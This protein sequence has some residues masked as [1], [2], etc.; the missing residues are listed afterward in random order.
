ML[1]VELKSLEQEDLVLERTEWAQA[2]GIELTPE[3]NREPLVIYCELAKNG[4]MISAKGWVKSRML[5][6]C[7]RC[8][9][10]FEAPFKSFFEVHYRPQ[11]D[12][13]VETEEG[14]PE[15]EMEVVYF[16][17]D[18]LDIGDQIRQTVLLSVPMRALCKDDCRGLCGSCG[19][20][21]NSE[22]CDCQEPPADP[23]WDALKSFKF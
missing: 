6:T 12:E 13:M 11:P 21:L 18:I 7:G 22:S 4:D 15:G 2:L 3:V 14:F 23:R 20:D 9:K 16:Q 19:R 1:M 17:G 5:L 10:E 8:L